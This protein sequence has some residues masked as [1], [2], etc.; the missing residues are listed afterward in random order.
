MTAN[1]TIAT[2]SAVM[3][4]PSFCKAIER[5][6]CGVE[7]SR[8]RLPFA[9]S[10]ASVPDNARTD[11]SPRIT[12]SELPTRQEM[13]PPS[14]SMWMGSPSKPRRAI[15]S[16]DMPAMNVWR[17]AIVSNSRP[18]GAAVASMNRPPRPPTT[19]AAR[20]LSR[21]VLA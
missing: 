7:A 10:P 11:H 4:P 21:T 1:S 12:G 15:G 19:S 5:R 17:S 8:S 18:Y 9:A 2:V 6:L 20:R 16:A 14:V 13:K 3:C